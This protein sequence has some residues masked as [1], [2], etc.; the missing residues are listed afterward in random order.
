M[1]TRKL[2]KNSVYL[3]S[4]HVYVFYSTKDVTKEVNIALNQKP[5]WYHFFRSKGNRLNTISILIDE[6]ESIIVPFNQLLVMRSVLT[7]VSD[8]VDE[9]VS[10]GLANVK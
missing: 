10:E 5:K 1:S 4:E 3:K 9:E 8:L 7:D 2:Y 6:S